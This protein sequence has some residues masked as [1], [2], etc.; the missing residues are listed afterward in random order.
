MAEPESHN[1]RASITLRS[2]GL[3]LTEGVAGDD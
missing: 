1:M 2:E 3:V